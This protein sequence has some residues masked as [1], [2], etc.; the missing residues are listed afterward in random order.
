MKTIPFSDTAAGR[1]ARRAWLG[2]PEGCA[3]YNGIPDRLAR[4]LQKAK[5][6]ATSQ[7]SAWGVYREE[8]IDE[9]ALDGAPG[10]H[11]AYHLG[12][13]TRWVIAAAKV[14]SGYDDMPTKRRPRQAIELMARGV[15]FRYFAA[16]KGIS[17]LIAESR[18]NSAERV[19]TFEREREAF[20]GVWGARLDAALLVNDDG[21]N[22]RAVV[23]AVRELAAEMNAMNEWADVSGGHII[24]T[25][26]TPDEA[27]A[28]LDAAEAREQPV[29]KKGRSKRRG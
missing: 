5:G 15:G 21:E 27:L 22:P 24:F 26:G 28:L 20:F 25:W 14:M 17:A 29:V 18:H 11:G 1:T 9:L 19:A 12:E 4:A 6:S 16:C 23:R 8:L 13:C 2:T 3:H 7:I 10:S